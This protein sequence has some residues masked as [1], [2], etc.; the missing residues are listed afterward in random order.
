[1]V[2]WWDLVDTVAK[3]GGCVKIEELFWARCLRNTVCRETSFYFS[4][5]F[6]TWRK[7]NLTIAMLVAQERCC[8]PICTQ[9]WSAVCRLQSTSTPSYWLFWFNDHR[10]WMD[11]IFGSRLKIKLLYIP[12]ISRRQCKL[13]VHKI[14]S[15]TIFA[16][17]QWVL[18]PTYLL[19]A[20]ESFLRS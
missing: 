8:L 19:H 7:R 12:E 17:C 20:A 16:C 11:G 9:W 1:V 5:V 4:R 6:T 14:G 10:L 15:E 18:Q 13:G 3:C 2:R